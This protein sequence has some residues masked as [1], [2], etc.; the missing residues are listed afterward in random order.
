VGEQKLKP[1]AARPSA[2]PPTASPEEYGEECGGKGGVPYFSVSHGSGRVTKVTVWH[3]VYVDGI[4]LETDLG[5][6]PR[7][8]GTGLHHDV[9]RDTFSLATDEFIKGIT[10]VYWRY[11][12]RITFHTNKR[13]CGP[14]GGEGGL[15]KKRLMAPSGRVVVGFK[16]RHWE[17]VDSIQLMVL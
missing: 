15:L 6:L 1:A 4:Q 5:V 8:G 14:Y 17:L 12:D 16:G 11:I 9:Q 7:I 10:V 3:R 13:D 2:K